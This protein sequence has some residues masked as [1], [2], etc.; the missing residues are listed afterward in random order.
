MDS[1]AFMAKVRH[2]FRRENLPRSRAARVTLGV[3][4]SV[5]GI[6][7]VV[8]PVLGL[9]MLPLGIAVLSVDSHV[10]RRFARKA[11]VKW[12]RAR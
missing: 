2:L 7:G 3:A 6:T 11:K 5:G 1:K 4:L 12:G 8:L 10:V 9:W